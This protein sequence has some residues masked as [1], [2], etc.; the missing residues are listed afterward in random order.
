MSDEREFGIRIKTTADLKGAHETRE[1]LKGLE[2]ST[3]D[4]LDPAF[5]HFAETT[6]NLGKETEKLHITHRE[7][8]RTLHLLGPEFAMVGHLGM[9]AF[10]NP[11]LLGIVAVVGA[12]KAL[13]MA[14]KSL[15]REMPDLGGS[16]A[17]N[18]QK[19][20]DGVAQS[21]IAAE[22]FWASL[23][24]GVGIE[25]NL[26]RATND[27]VEVIKA[28]AKAQ[29]EIDDANKK[30][31]GGFTDQQGID[32]DNAERTSIHHEHF[33]AMRATQAEAENAKSAIP[34]LQS[35]YDRAMSLAEANAD[36]ITKARA[37]DL[38]DTAALRLL[39]GEKGNL[40]D[41]EREAALDRKE[42]LRQF[43][44]AQS[45]LK[46][47]AD[48]AH[49]AL[50]QAETTARS[51]QTKAEQLGHA[52]LQ[53]ESINAIEMGGAQGA[54]NIRRRDAAAGAL[55]SIGAN[56]KSAGALTLMQ[57]IQAE[58]SVA[59]GGRL[60]AGQVADLETLRSALRVRGN[61]DS[62]I[63]GLFRE[64]LDMNVSSL[65]KWQDLTKALKYTKAQHA[66]MMAPTGS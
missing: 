17:P 56:P 10:A 53:E 61:A 44:E 7:L 43:E 21:Q 20:R 13:D 8:G 62:A 1:G 30:A 15:I 42:R 55:R 35:E 12:M 3:K 18:L 59:R 50:T 6:K 23:E 58:E 64:M 16:I 32:R 46:I 2:Q 36:R 40:T 54:E 28:Q 47:S 26:S 49:R 25:E 31:G 66:Q 48:E 22:E 51:L 34:R 5:A 33:L 11:I 65:Q 39:P 9:A 60:G 57:D 38:K 41:E 27:T 14:T 19:I 24:R 37:N 52:Y 63:E 4:G 29:K 45:G